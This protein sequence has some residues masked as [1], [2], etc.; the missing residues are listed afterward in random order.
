MPM[1]R[2][3]KVKTKNAGASRRASRRTLPRHRQYGAVPVRFAPR[4]G[5][6]VLLLTSRG[7]GR[8]VIPKGWRMRRRT[9]AATAER[10][11][12]EEAGLKGRLWSRTPI[13]SYWYRKEDEDFTGSILVRVFMLAVDEQKREWPEQSHRET[14]WFPVERAASL[15]KEPGLAR[16]LRR[17]SKI[18][19]AQIRAGAP[20][21]RRNG[22]S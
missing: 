10:E 11:A 5:I 1:A 18:V 6:E 21:L 7:T 9:P 20:A 2:S 22:G 3:G 16:L 14:S 13:G 4:S 17:I 8:W 19:V 12:F 15:V